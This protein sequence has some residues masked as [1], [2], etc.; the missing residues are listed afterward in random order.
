MSAVV[1]APVEYQKASPQERRSVL[2]ASF[3]FF[4]DMFDIYLPVIALAPALAFFMPA[5]MD[6]GLKAI[7]VGLIFASTLIAR[8]VGSIIFGWL[9]DRI[10]RKKATVIAVTGAGVGTGLIALLPGY[11]QFGVLAVVLLIVLRFIDGVFLGG[12]YTGAVPLAMEHSVRSH[13]GRNAGLIAF[14]FPASYV[15]ISLLTLVVLQ[16]A[17]AGDPTAAYS[18]WGWRIAFGI[19]ALISFG[20]AFYYARSVHESPE[21]QKTAAISLAG[22]QKKPNPLKELLTGKHRVALLQAFILMTGV[23]FS[24]NAAIVILPPTIAATTG[25]TAVETSLA[26]VLAFL[27]VCVA[28]PLF[29]MLSQRIGRRA[30]FA[31]CGVASLVAIPLFVVFASGTVTGFWPVAGMITMIALLGI[32]AFGAIGAYMSE[33]FPISIRATGYGVGYSLALI[34]PSFYAFYT[35]GLSAIMPLEYAPTVL[36]AVG[37][38]LLIV[39]GLWSPETKDVDLGADA[40]DVIGAASVETSPAHV[41]AGAA[42]GGQ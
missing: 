16:F 39:G 30:F 20:F 12:E 24:S 27:V 21:W 35:A 26:L 11:E 38:A 19:G 6:P 8:P 1:G 28:Y 23:W 10:G 29:G 15:V 31:W 14:G 5:S 42:R 34:I 4:V 41:G 22:T 9:G 40:D 18:Q 3:G 36:L 2:G 33:R 7:L 25:L 37:G 17:P 32:P 13:R